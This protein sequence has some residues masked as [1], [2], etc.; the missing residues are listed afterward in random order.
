MA[1]KPKPRSEID[2]SDCS[3]KQQSDDGNG[4]RCE[5]E[6]VDVE[7]ME[8]LNQIDDVFQEEE[9][10]C[11]VSSS[12]SSSFGDSLCDRDADDFG[13]GDGDEA[14]SML[15]KDY[16]L[17]DGTQFLGLTKKKTDERW[18]RLTKSLMWRCK[19]IELKVKEIESQARGYEREVEDYY[20]SKQ[21]D[22]EKSKLE[23]LDGKAI[24]F[25]EQT[26]RRNV[27]KR[28]R[29]K[30]VEETT[31]VA[32]Y[33]SNHNLFS[34]SEKR[35]PV[36]VKS[37]YLDS[38]IGTGRKATGKQDGTED[39]CLLSELDCSDDF[40]AKLLIKIDEAQIKAR[41]LK[42]RVDQL[43]LDSQTTLI[44]ETIA[45]CHPDL[46]IQNGKQYALVEDSLTRNQREAS[47]QCIPADH[48]KPLLVPQ[49]PPTQSGGQLLT[50]ISPISS[51]SLRFHPI[52]EDLLMDD[53]EMN[54]EELEADEEKLDYFRKLI[55]EIT[56]V[57][58]SEES[59]AE[60]DPQPAT[61][62]C[63]TSH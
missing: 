5:E 22:L 43:M 31:D 42:K 40:L 41:S 55:N 48:T 60:K 63:K 35:V 14:Q 24:P 7:I 54:D 33:M 23:G 1:L 58:S 3:G 47:V 30:R 44:P 56:G 38:D 19:W 45:P 36:N 12:S 21:F 13:F 61:K 39:D 15:S 34:Y 20:L 51:K 57:V 46:R 62:R 52:L 50:N 49:I 27:F 17:P 18:K 4:V 11:E 25:R 28:G 37:Q 26:Q 9:G 16:P 32:A 2:V 59:N 53:K 8:C 10:L 29:R 6:D